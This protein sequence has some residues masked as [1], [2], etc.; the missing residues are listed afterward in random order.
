MDGFLIFVNK[1]LLVVFARTFV[2]SGATDLQRCTILVTCEAGESIKP[3]AERGF[4]SGTP[5]KVVRQVPARKAGDR[6][7]WLN[8]LSPAQR[9]DKISAIGP[10][11]LLGRTSLHPRLYA[12]GCSAA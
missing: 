6:I 4:A 10:G 1:Q 3:G 11:V 9:A 7:C 8:Q 12:I 2:G 5:G